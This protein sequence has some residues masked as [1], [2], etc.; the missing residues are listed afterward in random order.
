MARNILEVKRKLSTRKRY[1]IG[2]DLDRHIDTII[3]NSKA[4]AHVSRDEYR[5][6]ILRDC[7]EVSKELSYI[8]SKCESR[9]FSAC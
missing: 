5:E 4:V 7:G 2:P 3:E 8:T 6:T 9:M 1:S